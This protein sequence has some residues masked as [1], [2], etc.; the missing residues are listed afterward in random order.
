MQKDE[1]RKKLLAPGMNEAKEYDSID[2]Y[3]V[4]DDKKYRQKIDD[5]LRLINVPPAPP[6]DSVVKL[7]VNRPFNDVI[8]V[9]TAKK[10]NKE[11]IVVEEDSKFFEKYIN[12][13]ASQPAATANNGPNQFS[14]SQTEKPIEKKIGRAHV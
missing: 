10:L 6:S 5:T 9:P 1:W 11:E 8:P 2:A 7:D 14:E 4:R 13:S 3:H 12:Q